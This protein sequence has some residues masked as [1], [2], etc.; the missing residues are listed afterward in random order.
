MSLDEFHIIKFHIGPE[1][2]GLPTILESESNI[3]VLK[4]SIKFITTIFLFPRGK[5]SN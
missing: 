1:K 4:H 2:V 3:H 5:K